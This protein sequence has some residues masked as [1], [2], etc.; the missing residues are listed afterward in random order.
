MGDDNC[1]RHAKAA[2]KGEWIARRSGDKKKQEM[3]YLELGFCS[4]LDQT[5]Y[6]AAYS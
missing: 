5:G 3:P 4:L 2:T 1:A 6:H